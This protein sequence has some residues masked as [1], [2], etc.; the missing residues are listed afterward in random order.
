MFLFCHVSLSETAT[1]IQTEKIKD[2][3]KDTSE[4]LAL[5]VGFKGTDAF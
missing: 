5:F 3:N 4:I 2:N 1:A